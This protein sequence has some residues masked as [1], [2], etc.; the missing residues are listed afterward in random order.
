[1]LVNVAL[2]LGVI[3]VIEALEVLDDEL[4]KVKVGVAD[5]A[6]DVVLIDEDEE[7]EPVLTDEVDEELEVIFAEVD[8]VV[9]ADVMEDVIPVEVGFPVELLVEFLEIVVVEEKVE[10]GFDV[11][12]LVEFFDMVMLENLLVV[13]ELVV[14]VLF[15]NMLEDMDLVE[16]EDGGGGSGVDVTDWVFVIVAVVV[17][18]LLTWMLMLTMLTST[19]TLFW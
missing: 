15:L 6:L 13:F 19:I 14:M 18:P 17:C 10:V 12:M 2:M 5:E 11:A 16:M 9:F 7:E 3:R 1:M 8:E 4:D